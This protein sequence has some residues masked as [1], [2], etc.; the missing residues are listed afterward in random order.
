[1][2]LK[3]I[4]ELNAIAG[5]YVPALFNLGQNGVLHDDFA[6]CLH[7]SENKMYSI[8]PTVSKVRNNGLDGT[9]ENG[10]VSLTYKDQPIDLS[11]NITVRIDDGSNPNAEI[12]RVLRTF[13]ALSCLTKLK[14]FFRY[15][16]YRVTIS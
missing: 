11:E 10:G 9:G 13:F 2:T 6:I 1:M 5:H 8:F 15:I 3:K 7:L 16:K 14:L 4:R 12:F